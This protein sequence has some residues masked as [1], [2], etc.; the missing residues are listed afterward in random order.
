LQEIDLDLSSF[1][2]MIIYSE[3]EINTKWAYEKLN[4]MRMPNSKQ[5]KV[6]LISAI[7]KPVKEWKEFLFNDF[8]EVIFPLYPQLAEIKKQLCTQ[9]ALYASMSGSGSAVFGIF[10]NKPEKFS[11][12]ENWKIFAGKL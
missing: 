8:E 9:G 6:D 11:V 1:H 7:H 4:E 12:S 5:K 3:I 10:E 2:I